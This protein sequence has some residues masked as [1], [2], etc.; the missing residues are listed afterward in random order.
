M[1]KCYNVAPFL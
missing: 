1:T